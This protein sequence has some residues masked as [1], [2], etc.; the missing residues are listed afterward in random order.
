MCCTSPK[1]SNN[2]VGGN[3]LHMVRLQEFYQSLD[4]RGITDELHLFSG[5]S[6]ERRDQTG[7]T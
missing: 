4:K 7:I 3:R 2:F 6:Y 5:S 1:K